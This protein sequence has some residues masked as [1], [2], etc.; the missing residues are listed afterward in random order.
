[1][2]RADYERYKA[3]QNRENELVGEIQQAFAA[4]DFSKAD[5]LHTELAN[6]RRELY[7]TFEQNPRITLN[8]D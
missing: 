4:G 6:V 5:E 8:E 1:M 2:N 7:T 3:N